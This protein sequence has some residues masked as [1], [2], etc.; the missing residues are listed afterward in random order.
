MLPVLVERWWTLIPFGDTVGSLLEHFI[1]IWSHTSHCRH[2]RDLPMGEAWVLLTLSDTW[3]TV[4]A[5]YM[6][7]GETFLLGMRG[8]STHPGWLPAT[9]CWLSSGVWLAPSFSALS[10]AQSPQ[11]WHSSSLFPRSLAAFTEHALCAHAG[12]RGGM[13]P[14]PQSSLVMGY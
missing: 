1:A 4:G 2:G 5:Q 9:P 11:S 14:Q 8:H 13:K 7:E 6:P 10:L 12:Q 3:H